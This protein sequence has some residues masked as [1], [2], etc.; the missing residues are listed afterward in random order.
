M[1]ETCEQSASLVCVAVKEEEYLDLYR[2]PWRDDPWLSITDY[3]GVIVVGR[4]G[5]KLPQG[6]V[7]SA[8]LVLNQGMCESKSSVDKTMYIVLSGRG[9]G[10]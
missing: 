10:I 1:L 5:V 2:L 8:C 6:T 9:S 3:L 7:F 4:H